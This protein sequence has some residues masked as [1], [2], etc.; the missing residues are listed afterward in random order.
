MTKDHVPISV[1]KAIAPK[2]V[3]T[4]AVSRRLGISSETVRRLVKAGRLEG[5]QLGKRR[6]WQIRSSSVLKLIELRKLARPTK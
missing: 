1:P 3:S 5:W 2:F 4:S 6:H